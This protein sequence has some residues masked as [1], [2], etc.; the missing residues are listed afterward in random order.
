M[1]LYPTSV[2][3][4]ANVVRLYPDTRQ[5][6]PGE[7]NLWALYNNAVRG[8]ESGDLPLADCTSPVAIADATWNSGFTCIEIF[9]GKTW[10]VFYVGDDEDLFDYYKDD[11]T[12]PTAF[13][14][15][16]PVD[17]TIYEIYAADIPGAAGVAG[18]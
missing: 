13:G 15:P 17:G 11:Y 6:L 3:K 4:P 9:D 8:L 5:S 12:P 1:S 14:N 18:I 7:R 2:A 16:D 10:R